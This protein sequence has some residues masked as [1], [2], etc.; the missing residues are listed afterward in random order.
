[1]TSLTWKFLASIST[2]F[3]ALY[4]STPLAP[5]SGIGSIQILFHYRSCGFLFF[6]GVLTF[7]ILCS[8]APYR[9]GRLE[10]SRKGHFEE[11]TGNFPLP[12]TSGHQGA[13]D[14]SFQNPDEEKKNV[15]IREINRLRIEKG[16]TP[17]EIAPELNL[18][19]RLHS[20]DMAQNDF[21]SHKGSDRKKGGHRMRLAGYRWRSWGEVVGCGGDGDPAQMVA[22]WMYSRPHRKALLN[23]DFRDVGAG[24]A[25][26]PS[27]RYSHYWAV[28]LG[29]RQ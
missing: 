6:C 22:L 5:K 24:Y 4:S 19:A 17:L 13:A 20:E 14:L 27:G 15:L 12:F 16:L 1:M 18:A 11:S 3:K 26:E 28:S 21:A 23:P 7:F 9:P 10:P 25:Y 2:S 29:L 8:C